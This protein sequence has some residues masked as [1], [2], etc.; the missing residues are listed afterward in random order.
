MT[1]ILTIDA[2]KATGLGSDVLIVNAS[3]FT[4]AAAL[5]FIGSD[6]K[7]INVNFVGGLG[8][9]TL[10]T[11]KITEDGGD[12]LTGGLGIDT[13][14][15]IAS[16]QAAEV[17][18]LG[19]G[20]SDVLVVTSLARGVVATVKEDYR[21]TTSTSNSKSIADVVLNAASGI[22]INMVDASGLF[23]Y[24]INGGSSSSNLE[25]SN[26]SDSISGNAGI[27]TLYGNKGNDTI[28]GGGGADIMN[29]GRGVGLIKD[30]GNGADI[31]TH[32]QGSALVVYNTGVDTVTIKATRPGL[33]LAV[34]VAGER[35]VNAS[36][37][38]AAITLDGRGAGENIVNYTGGFGNDSIFGGS[39]GDALLGKD[40]NDTFTGGLAAD[41]ISVGNGSNTVVFTGGLTS[42]VISG[43]TTDDV[44]SFDLT[45]LEMD[46]AV[47]ENETLDFVTGSSISVTAGHAISMQE[48]AGA[49]S[50][51]PTTNVLKY[52]QTSVANAAAMEIA[53]ESN[54]GIITTNGAL[55]ENDAFII[56]YK[57]SDTD[58]YSYAIAHVED[59]NVSANTKIAA[60]EVTDVGTTDFS[61]PFSSEQFAFSA[62]QVAQG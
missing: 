40:G 32:D 59:S 18:D 23:G 58:T 55:A 15:I 19:T 34:N 3:E 10:T 36:T 17:T 60:W 43:Y 5:T 22:D 12:T 51:Q 50:L 42:D 35:T 56:Q 28:E 46:D 62:S 61:A 31:I 6:D 29:A 54:G 47:E 49:I 7:D 2:S 14:N 48:V 37:S 41:T 38:T 1:G 33:Y 16:D 57:D 27:D 20:G 25:G 11:G 13:F 45:K 52:T 21:A 24:V 4:S 26:L 30:A 39:V 8:N 53:L 44:G 9:D